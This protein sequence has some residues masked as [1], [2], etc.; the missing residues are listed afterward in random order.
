MTKN[1]YI[2]SVPEHSW[3]YPRRRMLQLMAGA[4]AAALGSSTWDSPLPTR[5]VRPSG[6]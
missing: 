1:T 4:G 3:Q 2:H 5:R 6:G